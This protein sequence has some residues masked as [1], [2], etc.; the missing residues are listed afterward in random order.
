MEH[1]DDDADANEL[2]NVAYSVE[3]PEDNR[4]LYS[5]WAASYDTDFIEATGYVYHE[6]VVH[7]FIDAGGGAGGAVADVGC[8]T[9]VLGV[10]LGDLGEYV[11]DG[12]DI[13]AEML[14]QAAAKTTVHGEPAYRNLIEADF[15]THVPVDDD[16]YMGVVSSGAF[17]HG[18]LGPEALG[19]VVRIA[20]PTA[21]CA[22][23]V[24]EHHFV[25][26]G[27]EKWFAEAA[28]QGLITVPELVSVAMYEHL[29][30][31]HAGT[32]AAL[33]LFQVRA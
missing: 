20:S 22:I 13:S 31:E 15:T 21:V 24:N 3:T 4:N 28:G 8:G 12:L 18:H 27:F 26:L 14:S 5:K 23:G 25:E 9:G 2:L 30:G 33:A 19:E 16:T 32:R 29:D 6:N 1:L 11:V 7:A 17:T 10:S